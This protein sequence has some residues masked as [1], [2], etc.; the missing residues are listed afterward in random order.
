[1]DRHISYRDRFNEV[2]SVS[3]DDLWGYARN[4]RPYICFTGTKYLGLL[5]A[6]QRKRKSEDNFGRFIIIGQLSVFQVNMMTHRDPTNILAG[7]W[8]TNQLFYSIKEGKPY[9]Y[10]GPEFEKLIADDPELLAE[11][12]SLELNDKKKRMFSFVLRYNER[13][14]LYFPAYSP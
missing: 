10:N 11:F 6:D 8:D 14:P 1:M 4:G 2:R 12:S 3:V 7:T 13:H 9:D 5:V